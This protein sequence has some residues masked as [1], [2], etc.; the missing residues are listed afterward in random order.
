MTVLIDSQS[1]QKSANVRYF[2]D[3]EMLIRAKH[4]CEVDLHSRIESGRPGGR[5]KRVKT[6]KESKNTKGNV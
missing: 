2:Q 6:R 3:A 5:K 4:T 1:T